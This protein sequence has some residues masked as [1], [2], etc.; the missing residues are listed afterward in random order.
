MQQLRENFLVACSDDKTI[1]LIDCQALRNDPAYVPRYM[2]GH[3]KAVSRVQV[4]DEG[5]VLS[6]S[7]DLS[8]RK[9]R[10]CLNE[11]YVYVVYHA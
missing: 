6:A 11:F 3:T 8:I 7:R 9:V 4:L 10:H 2:K 1:S 5:T